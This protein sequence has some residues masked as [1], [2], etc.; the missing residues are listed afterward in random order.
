LVHQT[1]RKEKPLTL[2]GH[3]SDTYEPSTASWRLHGI[4]AKRRPRVQ[5][6]QSK[7]PWIQSHLSTPEGGKPTNALSLIHTAYLRR[8]QIPCHGQPTRCAE[9]LTH[10]YPVVSGK[11]IFHQR[12]SLIKRSSSMEKRNPLFEGKLKSSFIKRGFCLVSPGEYYRSL[13]SHWL[14]S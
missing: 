11:A 13:K 14:N 3:P 2:S 8:S 6:G 12:R 9:G 7:D 4:E 1:A 10:G 5:Q